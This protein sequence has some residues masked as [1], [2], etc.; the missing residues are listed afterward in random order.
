MLNKQDIKACLNRELLPIAPAY[1][2]WFDSD[3]VNTYKSFISEM[4]KKCDALDITVVV[5]II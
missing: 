1:F 3:F 4:H 2:F 5:E